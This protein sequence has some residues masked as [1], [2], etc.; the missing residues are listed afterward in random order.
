MSETQEE[1]ESL[2]TSQSAEEFRQA[3]DEFTGVL[4]SFADAVLS[5]A[6][7]PQ[8]EREKAHEEVARELGHALGRLNAAEAKWCGETSFWPE[9]DDEDAED[10]EEDGDEPGS[11]QDAVLLIRA[12]LEISDPDKLRDLAR[13][14][15]EDCAEVQPGVVGSLQALLPSI[16]YGIEDGFDSSA[17]LRWGYACVS[18]ERW[19]VPDDIDEDGGNLIFSPVE[20]DD[21][22]SFVLHG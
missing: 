4:R 9:E 11:T 18:G 13:T 10:G 15:G 7:L 12:D 21:L 14:R 22:R 5:L 16:V 2:Y 6:D 1:F 20:D 8:A 19:D 17:T 3:T